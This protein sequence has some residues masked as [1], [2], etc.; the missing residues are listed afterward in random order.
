M[1]KT[2]QKLLLTTVSLTTAFSLAACSSKEDTPKKAEPSKNT[3]QVLHLMETDEIPT[4]NNVIATDP[5]SFQAMN[6]VMEGLYRNGKGD[7][8]ENGV[9]EKEEVSKD[10]K[11]YTFHL[12][13]DAKWSNGD[14]VTAKDF[15]YG[16]Q[17]LV[18]PATAAQY[19]Y[20]AYDIKNAEKI[21]K[22]EAKPSELG[23]TAKDDHTLVVE[24][25]Q[26]VA[27]FKKLMTFPV[28]YPVNEKFEKEQKGTFGLEAHTTLYNGPFVLSEWKHD[29][30]FQMKKNNKYWDKKEVKLEE[31]NFDIIKDSSTALNLYQTEELD[32]IPTTSDSVEKFKDSKELKKM[33]IPSV[34]FLRFN[35]NNEVLKNENARK[36]LSMAFDKK[37]LTEQFLNDGSKATDY[38]VIKDIMKNENGK[39]FREG[40]AETKKAD[41]K[42]M[43]ELW[44]KAL[45][46]TGK[47]KVTLKLLNYDKDPLKKIG[48]Y[49][50]SEMEKNLP[51]LTVEIKMQ[52]LAQ[53]L[54]MEKALDYDISISS[55]TSDYPDPMNFL[56]MYVGGSANNRTGFNDPKYNEM[57][58]TIKKKEGGDVDKRWKSMEDAEKYLL[59]KAVVAPIYV[60][61]SVYLERGYVKDVYDHSFGGPQSYKWAYVSDEK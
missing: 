20:I 44:E 18:D 21:N 56:D 14:P 57:I 42:E 23:V 49:L 5:V 41:T 10:G 16:W 47:D 11:T 38:Y 37:A 46:E 39:V 1:K 13:K 31:I 26:P 33:S 36:A 7:K 30:S 6:N 12:R 17:K 51:G 8:L 43:K 35:E 9:A 32:R 15:V 61:G 25:E 27:Y 34:V 52:P 4:M 45:K 28:F 48:E 2:K 24:L 54:K 58:D 60:K 55:W 19:A 29:Q 50:K 3:K 53:K 59:D 40:V 22:K